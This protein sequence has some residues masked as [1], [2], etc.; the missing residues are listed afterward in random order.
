MGLMKSLHK[1]R[2]QAAAE[3]KAA[4]KRASKEV[5]NRYRS[6]ERREWLL[7]RQEKQLIKAEKKGLKAKRK[8]DEKMAKNQLE[9]LRAGKF[10]KDNVKRWAGAARLLTPLLIPVAYRA[11]TAGREKLDERRARRLG[12]SAQELAQFTGHGAALQARIHGVRK[13][14]SKAALPSGFRQDAEHRLDELSNA[15]DNAEYMTPE[16]R[17]RAHSAISADVDA[18]AAEIHQ[19]LT[20]AE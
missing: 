1:R 3:I 4:K 13:A 15:V 2:V 17:R 12:V 8:H 14:V 16:Q 10:N 5:R 6:A 19:R 20:R 11:I 9:Q 7:A 18:L